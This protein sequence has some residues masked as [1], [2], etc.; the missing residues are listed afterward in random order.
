MSKIVYFLNCQVRFT[1][2]HIH[3]TN[4]LSYHKIKTEFL[5]VYREKRALL[6]F[7]NYPTYC[8]NTQKSVFCT[9][10][11]FAIIEINA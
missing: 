4:Y 9:Y 2:C 11:T 5:P 3:K 7:S 10:I 1:L 6:G 8:S